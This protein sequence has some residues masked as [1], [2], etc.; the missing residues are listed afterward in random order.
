M[1]QNNRHQAAGHQVASEQPTDSTKKPQKLLLAEMFERLHRRNPG[2]LPETTKGTILAAWREGRIPLI[3]SE[4][5]EYRPLPATA[6][7]IGVEQV[8]SSNQLIPADIPPTDIAF[9]W[10][11][12]KAV[13]DDETGPITEFFDVGAMRDAFDREWPVDETLPRT[14][15]GAKGYGEETWKL[16]EVHFYLLLDNDAKSAYADIDATDYA[17]KLATWGHQHTYIGETM[18]PEAETIRRK[19]PEWVK[20]WRMLQAS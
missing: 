18:T 13:W 2:V 4:V 19:I 17:N 15:R 11:I 9:H 1:P 20:F 8:L 3:A 6:P 5:R 12:N 14:K 10:A 7:T 16:L